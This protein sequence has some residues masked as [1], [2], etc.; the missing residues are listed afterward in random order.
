MAASPSSERIR[1][2]VLGDSDSHAYQ[3]D[4]NMP[5]PGAR[6]GAF[7]TATFQWTE[8]L[9]RLRSDTVH[10]GDWGTWG[11][12]RWSLAFGKRL[13]LSLRAP[14]KRDYEFNFAVSGARCTDLVSGPFAQSAQLSRLMSTEPQAWRRA[15]VVIRI[16]INDIGKVEDLQRMA[17]DGPGAVAAKVRDC[18]ASIAGA[19]DTIR[20]EHRDVRIL[21]VGILNNIDWPPNLDAWQSARASANITA[22]LDTFDRGLVSLVA[23]TPGAAFFDDRQWFAAKWGGRDAVGR[24][25]YRPVRLADL[26]AV[27]LSQGDAW[28]HAVLADGHAGLAWNVLWAQSL[29][30]ALND[31]FDLGVAEISDGELR[32]FVRKVRPELAGAVRVASHLQGRD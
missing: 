9:A 18:L 24:P 7:R 26:P 31:A 15:V 28:H 10:L 27:V 22:A 16:G 20:A 5:E 23:R 14:R 17:I 12:G 32:D 30:A 6:G 8:V 13:G 3:D 11:S 21:L 29:I 25:D 19:V 2:A 4:L 1:L